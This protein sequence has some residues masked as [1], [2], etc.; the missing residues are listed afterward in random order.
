MNI[1]FDPKKDAINQ[2]KHGLSLSSARNLN[3]NTAILW[4]DERKEYGEIRMAALALLDARV[5]FAAFVDRDA[6]RRIISLRKAN[7]REVDF[8]VRN[9]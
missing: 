6:E 1:T 5:H 3:W 8:Y 4:A 2:A 7:P 9:K